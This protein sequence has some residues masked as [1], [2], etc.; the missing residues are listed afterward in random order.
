MHTPA[1]KRK[2]INTTQNI[3]IVYNLEDFVLSKNFDLKEN[4]SDLESVVN[5]DNFKE[6]KST[7]DQIN[8]CNNHNK[9]RRL[10][11]HRLTN[12]QGKICDQVINLNN[13]QQADKNRKNAIILSLPQ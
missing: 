8:G 12:N 7:R 13:I 1:D 3:K 10:S 4:T 6:Q 9:L 11:N 2:M 5:Q